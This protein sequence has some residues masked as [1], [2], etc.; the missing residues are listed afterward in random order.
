[1][2]KITVHFPA[3]RS[4]NVHLYI[5]EETAIMSVQVENLEKNI[6]SKNRTG[7]LE[8]SNF[9]ILYTKELKREGRE[10]KDQMGKIFIRQQEAKF[11]LGTSLCARNRKQRFDIILSIWYNIL[12]RKGVYFLC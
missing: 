7:V 1:M 9:C 10:K 12:Y 2:T 5:K 4:D 8:Q 6:H 11:Y 3:K